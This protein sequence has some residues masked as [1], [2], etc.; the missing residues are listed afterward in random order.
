MQNEIWVDIP[1][2]E[3]LY[4]I[5]SLGRVKSLQRVIERGNGKKYTVSEKML[6]HSLRNGYPIVQLYKDKKRKT[7][8]IHK[9]MQRAFKIGDVD[10]HIDHIDRNRQNNHLSNLR[11]VSQ[12]QNTQNMS[13]KS[14]LPVGVD[15]HKPTGKY[16]AHIRI[17]GKQKYLGVFKTSDKASEAYQKALKQNNLVFIDDISN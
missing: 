9:I 5:S 17:E 15:F 3:G 12:R 11:A 4:Q 14:N 13:K 2:Y 10:L 8:K 7:M 16:R 6:K 1:D